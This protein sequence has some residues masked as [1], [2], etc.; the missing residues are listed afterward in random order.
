MSLRGW[1]G[2]GLVRWGLRVLGVDPDHG[3]PGARGEDGED[4]EG[5]PAQPP[6]PKEALAMIDTAAPPKKRESPRV[7]VLAGSAQERALMAR[8]R[9]EMGR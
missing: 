5:A 4:P 3:P 2:N 9:R 6:V 7:H 8:A 1:I